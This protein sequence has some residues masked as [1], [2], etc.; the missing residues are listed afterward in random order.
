MVEARDSESSMT[1]VRFVGCWDTRLT[2]MEPWEEFWREFCV[3][4][5]NIYT[6]LCRYLCLLQLICHYNLCA[7]AT[8][9]ALVVAVAFLETGE[10]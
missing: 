9:L 8:K 2:G 3:V 4:S 1:V 6:M 10:E 7:T 5:V